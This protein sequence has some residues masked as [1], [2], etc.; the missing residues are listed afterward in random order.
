MKLETIW[1]VR[2]P[3]A[4]STLTDICFEVRSDRLYRYA[5]GCTLREWEREH[6]TMYT[7][8]DE[9][10]VDA[11]H[12]L[13]RAT[14]ATS[15]AADDLTWDGRIAAVLREPEAGPDA[16]PADALHKRLA[17]IVR[18][19]FEQAVANAQEL[20]A[21]A[22]RVLRDFADDGIAARARGVELAG[23]VNQLTLAAGEL[24]AAKDAF[25]ASIGTRDRYAQR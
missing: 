16:A 12:R 5:I 4:T 9:A 24:S 11:R 6:H 10:R 8:A 14:G 7:T 19:R 3:S 15:P 21:A 22:E 17:G 18:N 1:V 20:K 25:Q 2:D 23:L 13:A